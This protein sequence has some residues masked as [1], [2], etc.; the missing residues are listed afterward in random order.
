MELQSLLAS[1]SAQGVQI[2]LDGDSLLIE[3]P[4]ESITPE[5]R[6]SLIE[7]K[8][9]LL[10]LLRQSNE[11]AN[12]TSLPSI[13]SDLT[14]RCEPF[15]LTD[16]QHAF[17]VGRSGVLEL[18]EVAN[19]GYYEIDCQQLAL[20]RLNASLNQLINRHDMLRAI[21]LPDGRQQVLQEVPVYEIQLFDLDRKS[22]V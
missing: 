15:P 2:S 12:S 11:I 16:A 18:G 10:R 19:H 3:A 20:A 13:K 22:V 14:R 9:E 17:W 6:D 21:V 4:K 5:L 8:G 1:L 7:H